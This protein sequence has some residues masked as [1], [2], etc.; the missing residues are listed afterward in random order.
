M[1]FLGSLGKA[2]VCRGAVVGTVVAPKLSLDGLL[3][4]HPLIFAV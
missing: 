2:I 3:L 4:T 1:L